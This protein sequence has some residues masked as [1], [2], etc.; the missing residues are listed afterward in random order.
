MIFNICNNDYR[1]IV[2]VVYKRGIVYV[3]GVFT[4]AEYDTVD[5]SKFE[6][7][8]SGPSKLVRY[9]PFRLQLGYQRR[10]A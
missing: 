5:L 7:P 2:N 6:R 8:K 10:K 1:L 3:K 4:H 9:K